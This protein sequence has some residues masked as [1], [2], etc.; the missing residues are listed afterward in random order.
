MLIDPGRAGL[1]RY[2]SV[3]ND[4]DVDDRSILAFA[5]SRMSCDITQT[6]GSLDHFIIDR[7]NDDMSR[8]R[9]VTWR[10]GTSEVAEFGAGRRAGLA[11]L[12]PTR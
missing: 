2:K 9:I 5:T 4:L 7:F 12:G 6:A 8:F 10:E 1:Y 11:W 3:F